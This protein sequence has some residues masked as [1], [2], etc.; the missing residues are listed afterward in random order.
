MTDHDAVEPPAGLEERVVGTLRTRGL[1]RGAGACRAGSLARRAGPGPWRSPRASCSSSEASPWAAGRL[2]IRRP[3][4]RS[5]RC[6]C[7]RAPDSTPR[8]RRS[9]SWCGSTAAGP[10]SWPV[11][12]SSWPARSWASSG[13]PSARTAPPRLAPAGFFV[14]AARD[15]R[16]ALAIARTCPHLRYGGTVSVRP[17]EPT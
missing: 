7:T 13:G 4:W 2:P 3:D 14:I 11:A 5:T 10:G 12:A 1:L 16:E 17:I 8:A 9:P 15:E 6:S